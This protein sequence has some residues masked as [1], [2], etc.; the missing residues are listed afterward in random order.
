MIARSPRPTGQ[1]EDM[2]L[3]LV[4]H[5][6]IGWVTMP[7]D[8]GLD[9]SGLTQARRTRDRFV[10]REVVAVYGSPLRRAR[11]TAEVIAAGQGLSVHTEVRLRELMNW[12]DVPGQTW[13]EFEALW[14]TCVRNH[15]HEPPG[16]SP[17]REVLRRFGEWIEHAR[18]AHPDGEVVAVT[19]GGVIS[20]YVTG[21][22]DPQ[23]LRE[24]N[25]DF[26][27]SMPHC[28]VTSLRCHG[29]SV[30]VVALADV[31]HLD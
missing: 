22:A 7:G 8:H 26:P 31:S 16:G 9:E 17:A 20:E 24:L 1:T 14:H 30:E 2:L 15:D 11:E 19:P 18:A 3:H 4:R 6:S 21:V 25:P 27:D 23:R 12:G 5:G 29:G 28:S 13:E 10:D